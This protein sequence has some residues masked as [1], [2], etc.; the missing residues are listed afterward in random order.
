[1]AKRKVV[2]KRTSGGTPKYVPP[3]KKKVR[4]YIS[5]VGYKEVTPK[6]R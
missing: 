2:I 1:M 5:G 6:E 3:K 4:T